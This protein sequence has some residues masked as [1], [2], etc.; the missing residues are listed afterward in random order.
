MVIEDKV[1][2]AGS[3]GGG[4]GG[5]TSGST[6]RLR[7]VVKRLQAR[8][9]DEDS[10]VTIAHGPCAARR[11]HQPPDET[12]RANGPEYWQR[13]RHSLLRTTAALEY[14]ATREGRP[15]QSQSGVSPHP[16]QLLAQVQRLCLPLQAA[17]PPSDR[18]RRTRRPL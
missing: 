6:S 13:R 15:T 4:G 11:G 1:R 9:E 7:V 2:L 12:K 10:L 8:L 14:S 5:E 17:L 16:Q 3:G 18:Q